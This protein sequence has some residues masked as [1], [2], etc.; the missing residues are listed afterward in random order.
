[1]NKLEKIKF[2]DSWEITLNEYEELFNEII[3]YQ[4]NICIEEKKSETIVKIF[5]L[6]LQK[7]LRRLIEDYMFNK[8]EDLSNTF[9]DDF[10]QEYFTFMYNIL[11]SL[12][13]FFVEYYGMS[14]VELKKIIISIENEIHSSSKKDFLKR[15]KELHYFAFDSFKKNFWY[16]EGCPRVWNKI[17]EKEIT[18]LKL[19]YLQENDFIFSIFTHFKILNNPLKCN[20]F[21]FILK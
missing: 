3:E 14:R 13:L 15:V 6:N 21:I 16:N 7:K 9:W 11:I 18:D 17:D 1:M 8:M 10:N 12:D 20:I 2:F 5:I 4:R 19:K